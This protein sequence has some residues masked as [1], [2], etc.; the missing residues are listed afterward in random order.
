M[1]SCYVTKNKTV[2]HQFTNEYNVD[3]DRELFS[4]HVLH[5]LDDRH[6]VI[7]MTNN[8]DSNYLFNWSRSSILLNETIV[9]LNSTFINSELI[10]ERIESLDDTQIV[11]KDIQVL[12]DSINTVLLPP[13]HI[14][15]VMILLTAELHTAQISLSDTIIDIDIE[16]RLTFSEP[17][18]SEYYTNTY[19]LERIGASTVKNEQVG[20]NTLKTRES[21]EELDGGK[22]LKNFFTLTL[23]SAVLIAAVLSEG[24]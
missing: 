11:K 1:S 7:K 18:E 17:D 20:L 22:T 4:I 5:Q 14:Y 13:N 24:Y 15:K 19:N 10:Y 2:Y 12:N 16:T 3:F 21:Y 8:S 6:M 23:T 9:P